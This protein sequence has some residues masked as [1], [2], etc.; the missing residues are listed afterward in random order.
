ME[1]RSTTTI[2]APAN[3]VWLALSA[4][5]HWP[6]WLPTVTSLERLDSG[7]LRVGSQ[8]K[9]KQPKLPPL[10]WTVTE[11]LPEKSFAWTTRSAGVTTI[12]D[13]QVAGEGD[14]VTVTLI[15]RQEGPL[16][17]LAALFWGKQTR[18]YLEME[19]QSLKQRCESRPVANPVEAI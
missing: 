5:E 14:G 3:Q 13:H 15:I 2:A 4:V 7:P 17:G 6:D 18:R 19:G 10:T 8:A 9:I 12:G 11:F 1:Y 16:A